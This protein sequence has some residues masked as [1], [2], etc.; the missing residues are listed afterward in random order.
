MLETVKRLAK[1]PGCISPEERREA[2]DELR[3]ALRQAETQ[4]DLPEWLIENAEDG[5]D[6]LADIGEI[7]VL[8]RLDDL[9]V[10]GELRG[11]VKRAADRSKPKTL[12]A[13]ATALLG[14]REGCRRLAAWADDGYAHPDAHHLLKADITPTDDAGHSEKLHT[15]D[16]ADNSSKNLL[17]SNARRLRTDNWAFDEAATEGTVLDYV[18]TGDKSTVVAD[19][20]DHGAILHTPPSRESGGG[21][22]VPL[23]GLDATG[24]AELWAT[25]LGEAVGTAD[26]HTTERER[27]EFLESAL[28]LRVIQTADRPRPYEGDPT[29]KDT[30]GDVALLESIAEEYA[31]IEAPRA[32]DD[33]VDAVGKPAAITTKGV[34]EVLENDSR[35][36]DVVAEFE[37]Y[38]NVTGANDLGEHRLAAILGSQHYGDDA[39][40]RFCALAGEEVDTSRDGGRGAALDYGS[41]LGDTYLKHMRDDQVM[42]A[43][44]RFARGDSGATVVARTSALRGDLPVVGRGQVVETWDDTATEIARRYRRLGGEFTVADVA[45]AVDVSTRQV[46]R[47]LGELT[48]AGYLRRVVDRNGVAGV[49]E[50]A[51]ESP[52]AGEA[53][54]PDRGEAVENE[55]TPGHS[56]HSE[57]YTWNVQVSGVAEG[58]IGGDTVAEPSALGAPPSPTADDGVE[59]PS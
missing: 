26:I 13:A 50:P 52:G 31:G 40:E 12:K 37:N 32:R 44:L 42:Q 24:R 34:R 33:A 8:D 22:E 56:T 20:N 28:S 58:V 53:D 46:R 48:E 54:L 3:D 55:A 39:I 25:A 36:D 38:G 11:V 41:E 4:A 7:G 9:P 43:V 23:V 57:Y 49:W 27:A 15:A 45:D 6:D 21:G 14:G 1:D 17:E 10:G 18:E 19:R 51:A 5:L 2:V 59:P 29:T 30:D 35:L 16:E 47:V